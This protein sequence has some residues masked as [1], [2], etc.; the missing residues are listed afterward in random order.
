MVDVALVLGREGGPRHVRAVSRN[1][2]LPRAHDLSAG[3]TAPYEL[4]HGAFT[5]DELV[6]DV[7][8]RIVEEEVAGGD[9]RSVI[10]SLRPVTN[11]IWA[12]LGVPDRERFVR[13]VSRHWEVRRHRMAP[14][15]AR[16]LDAL[17][18][19]GKLTMG[20]ASILAMRP[21]PGGIEVRMAEH[22]AA[23][24]ETVVVS[25][26]VNC[27]GPSLQ[28][29]VAGEPLLRT[30]LD[31]GHVRPGPF[32]LGLDHDSRGA[33]V[34]AEGRSSRLLYGMGP[35]RKGRLWETTAIPEIR[36]QSF[37]LAD[38]LTAQLTSR[39]AQAGRAA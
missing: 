22:D 39:T 18:A 9:W 7:E 25:R 15:V 17:S 24:E 3:A 20:R 31:A 32:S 19:A 35:V 28:V 2:L 34:D 11:R 36:A 37:E 13:E 16:M 29:A 12:R 23:P 26:V 33:L 14:E 21:V 38:L 10:D 27:T 30:L 8:R 6:A 4:P 1:G 5:L